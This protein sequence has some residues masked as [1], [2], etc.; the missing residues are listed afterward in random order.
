MP[1]LDLNTIFN[2][3]NLFGVLIALVAASFLETAYASGRAR[4]K[5]LQTDKF[6]RPPMTVSGT[7]SSTAQPKTKY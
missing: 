4:G 2:M 3:K 1:V 7:T 5:A 6:P